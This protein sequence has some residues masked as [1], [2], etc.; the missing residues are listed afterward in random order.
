MITA[1][2]M[3][4]LRI[5]IKQARPFKEKLSKAGDFSSAMK[6]HMENIAPH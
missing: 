5:L 2:V 3:K 4:E 6:Y 1:S